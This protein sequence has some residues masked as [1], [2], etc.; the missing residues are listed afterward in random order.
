MRLR[1]K[2]CI[3]MLSMF[4]C[5]A[6]AQSALWKHFSASLPGIDPQRVQLSEARSHAI[7]VQ[8]AAFHTPYKQVCDIDQ[9]DQ[10]LSFFRVPLSTRKVTWVLHQ[11]ESG[12][13][14]DEYLFA[15]VGHRPL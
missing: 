5:T 3:L 15:W 4:C 14:P 10:P 8:V 2:L 9:K 11:C 6:F 7:G 13:D 12:S 1:R